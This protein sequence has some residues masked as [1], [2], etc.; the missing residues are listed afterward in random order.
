MDTLDHTTT[1]PT[2]L[3]SCASCGW[4]HVSTRVQIN[5]FEVT[6]F[7]CASCSPTRPRWEPSPGSGA[8]AESRAVAFPRRLMALLGRRWSR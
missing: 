8:D 7:W 2:A 5:E 1:A 6:A 3:L 4:P